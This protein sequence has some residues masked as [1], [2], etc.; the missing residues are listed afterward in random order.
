MRPREH[1]P[2][3]IL[4]R[5][6]RPGPEQHAAANLGVPVAIGLTRTAKRNGMQHRDVVAN[7][8]RLANHNRMR[9]DRS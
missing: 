8:R 5:T 9:N 2:M 4:P 6:L 7:H 3:R 1:S